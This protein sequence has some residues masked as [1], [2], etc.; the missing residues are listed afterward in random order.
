MNTRILSNCFDKKTKNL[1]SDHETPP[2]AIKIAKTKH[3]KFKYV[4]MCI[5]IMKRKLADSEHII[6]SILLM[7]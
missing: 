7:Q 2:S 6:V 5:V 3:K 1:E 4:L